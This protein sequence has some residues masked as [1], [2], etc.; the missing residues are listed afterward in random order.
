MTE[1]N[2]LDHRTIILLVCSYENKS[3]LKPAKRENVY[4]NVVR[5]FKKR[6]CWNMAVV[7]KEAALTDFPNCGDTFDTSYYYLVCKPYTT[8]LL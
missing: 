6:K 3:Y 7:K 1:W 2:S 5:L 8:C 4:S